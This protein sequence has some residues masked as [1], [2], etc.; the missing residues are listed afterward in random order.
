M[1]ADAQFWQDA[2]FSKT[3][4]VVLLL[5]A[6]AGAG[7]EKRGAISAASWPLLLWGVLI[8]TSYGTMTL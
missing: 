2:A 3:I 4:F 7:E 5:I 8:I 1:H 6:V